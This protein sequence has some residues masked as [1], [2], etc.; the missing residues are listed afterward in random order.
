MFVKNNPRKAW[1]Q[2]SYGFLSRKTLDAHTDMHKTRRECKQTSLHH[3]LQAYE[4]MKTSW[5]G[6]DG[7][8]FVDKRMVLGENDTVHKLFQEMC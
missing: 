4:V 8:I 5:S 1:S 6:K 2:V 7:E 3:R